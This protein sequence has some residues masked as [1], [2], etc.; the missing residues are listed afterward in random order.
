MKYRLKTGMEGFEVVDGPQAG[1]RFVPGQEYCEA[2]IAGLS[3]A[4]AG[5]FEKVRRPR[6]RADAKG[7]GK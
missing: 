3:P 5:R 7:G 4:D 2:D 6:K 1:R